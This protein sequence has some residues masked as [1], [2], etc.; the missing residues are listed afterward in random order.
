M[1]KPAPVRLRSQIPVLSRESGPLP[2][3]WG[4]FVD[5]AIPAL[6]KERYSPRESWRKKPFTAEDA[7]FFLKGIQELSSVFT[8]ERSRKLSGYLNHPKYRSSYLLYFLPLQAAKIAQLLQVHSRAW[9]AMMT[10]ARAEGVLRVVDI[11]AG[12]GTASLALLL[13]LLDRQ[14]DWGFDRIEF[15]WIDLNAEIMADGQALLEHFAPRFQKGTL[16]LRLHVGDWKTRLRHV[17]AKASLVFFGNI[18]NEGSVFEEERPLWQEVL[19]R[20]QGGGLVMIEPAARGSSQMLSRLRNNLLESE[21]IPADPSAIWGPCLHAGICPMAEGRD[22]CH[23]SMRSELPGRWF[24]LFSRGLGGHREWLKFSYLWLA[25]REYSAEK[26]APNLR[27]V[28]SDPLTSRAHAREKEVLLC[29]PEQQS[30]Y[31]I[32]DLGRSAPSRGDLITVKDSVSRP[33]KLPK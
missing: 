28:I 22:W 16:D 33:G 31:K 12:P 13:L 15:D 17:P 25:S 19:S 10:H 30:R 1:T 32:Q 29:E 8:E 21:L 9:D 18:L 27:R 4:W 23:F 11:G 24:K 26:A 6:V 14:E 20:A 2:E 3:S 7:S 5:T